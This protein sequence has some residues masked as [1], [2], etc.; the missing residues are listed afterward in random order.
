MNQSN[1]KRILL[2]LSGEQLAGKF[3][4]GIDAEFCGWLAGEIKKVTDNGIG[5]VVIPGGGNMFRGRQVVEANSS[6]ERVTAEHMGMLGGLI[7]SIALADIFRSSGLS[8]KC[9]SNLFAPQVAESYSYELANQYLND[10]QV[11][12]VGGGTGRPY[13]THDTA[14]VNIGL[15]LN[16]QVVLKATKVDGVYNKDP[17]QFQ[18]AQKITAM[19]FAEAL[20][21]SDIKVMDKAALG[22]AMENQ[23]PIIVFDATRSDAVLKAAQGE[24]IGTRIDD[25]KS[26]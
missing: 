10:N 8:T 18:D 6:I 5:V 19:S 12:I 24:P 23:M 7:N 1:D 20:Q 21:N 14:A 15:E 9:L 13:F 26:A 25:S 11:V 2:K 22:L 4:H 16:C 17:M 3:D